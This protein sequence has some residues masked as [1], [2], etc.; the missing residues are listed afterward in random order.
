MGL[1][2]ILFFCKDNT[3][4][5]DDAWHNVIGT[6]DNSGVNLF[7]DGTQVASSTWAG[8]PGTPTQTAAFAIGSPDNVNATPAGLMSDIR[9][10]NRVLTSSEIQTIAKDK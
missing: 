9:I 7:I 2:L 10:Y 4:P 1:G 3:Y 5:T 6:E 8:A